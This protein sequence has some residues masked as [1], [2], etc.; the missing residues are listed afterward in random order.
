[1]TTAQLQQHARWK[2]AQINLGVYG[3]KAP[4]LPP[5]EPSFVVTA[6]EQPEWANARPAPSIPDYAPLDML[7]RPAAAFIIAYVAAK[8]DLKLPQML[9]S[10]RVASLVEPRQR[11]IAL[12]ASHTTMS[13]TMIG[14]VFGGLHYST[15][16]NAVGKYGTR[17]PHWQ[18]YSLRLWL[19][20]SEARPSIRQLRRQFLEQHNVTASVLFEGPKAIP[21]VKLRREV[22]LLMAGWGY[23]PTEIGREIGFDRTSVEYLLGRRR[24]RA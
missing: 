21:I 18:G 22:C 2:Q 20:P 11:A 10:S 3:F 19:D 16:I 13:Y 17:R 15:V 8:H 24:N 6:P 1:M 23:S 14:R 9:G 12:V 5:P 4:K 7:K